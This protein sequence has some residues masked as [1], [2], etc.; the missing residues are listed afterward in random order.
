MVRR[1][2]IESRP[3]DTHAQKHRIL[4]QRQRRHI[5]GEHRAAVAADD[6]PNPA[7]SGD[8]FAVMDVAVGISRIIRDILFEMQR[9][10]EQIRHQRL[11]RE[12]SLFIAFAGRAAPG[13]P[14]DHGIAVIMIKGVLFS[15][16]RSPPKKN[17]VRRIETAVFAAQ[18]F[19]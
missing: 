7:F 16:A 5:K 1:T 3:A 11:G 19:E 13:E 2:G 9:I 8:F 6:G 14:I 12:R 15:T 18:Q 10:S 17:L 4:L